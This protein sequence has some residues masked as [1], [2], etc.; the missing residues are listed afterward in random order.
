MSKNIVQK[1][2]DI[3]GVEGESE[4][5]K[6]QYRGG[7]GED[8]SKIL[9]RLKKKVNDLKADSSLRFLVVFLPILQIRIFIF[10]GA[11]N[12]F[13][14]SQII[15]F[16]TKFYKVSIA[17]LTKKSAH[18]RILSSF[19]I[20]SYNSY[21]YCSSRSFKVVTHRHKTT[22]LYERKSRCLLIFLQ[23]YRKRVVISG[24]YIL[25]CFSR[26]FEIVIFVEYA[27]LPKLL[28]SNGIRVE[29]INRML[30]A[31]FWPK[32]INEIKSKNVTFKNFW[33][34]KTRTRGE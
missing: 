11:K 26:S 31:R 9:F 6:Q 13:R 34:N 27:I 24:T 20:R 29:N 15:I 12:F 14:S 1:I 3:L 30:N 22:K 16:T 19:V 25:H 21:F 10:G 18:N 2:F 28:T 8:D 17:V 33:N 23:W 7:C 4:R 5:K 32:G